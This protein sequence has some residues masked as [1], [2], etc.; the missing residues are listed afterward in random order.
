MSSY[1]ALYGRVSGVA[2]VQHSRVIFISDHDGREIVLSN[3]TLGISLEGTNS[4]HYY[5]F[6]KLRPDVR[7]CIQ[8]IL[9]IQQLASY[10]VAPAREILAQAQRKKLKR[11]AL[12]GAPFFLSLGLLLLIPLVLA[13]I[14]ASWMAQILQPQHEKALG[15][16][17]L[18][19]MR[20]QFEIKDNHPAAVPTKKI[21]DFIKAANPELHTTEV[22]VYISTSKEIN[23]FAAPGNVIVVNRGL[24]DKADSVEEVAGVLA[25]E[26]G[27]IHQKH[28]VKSLAGGLGSLFGT[29]LLATFVGYDAALVVANASDFVSLKYSRDDELAADQQGFKFLNNAHV[30]TDGMISFFNKIAEMDKFLPSVLAL[31][32]THPSSVERA[33][34]LQ[35][36]SE[37]PL[38]VPLR[39]L[40]VS[41]EEIKNSFEG[42]K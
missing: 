13:L 2:E 28:V 5:V 22:E 4:H 15:N 19:M 37:E 42:D 17:L 9:A 3:T 14:P 11:S 34:A 27:H 31:A 16:L 39:S 10:G 18:P 12:A 26:L 25:H 29:V 7:I 6:D 36:L 1:P 35:T 20:L 38:E 40:P 41:L 23:A 24:I 30:S 21:I 8:N 33:A 32:S